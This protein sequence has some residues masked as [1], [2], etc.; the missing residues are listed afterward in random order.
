MSSLFPFDRPLSLPFASGFVR[1]PW[2]SVKS[3]S[4]RMPNY[5]IFF[6]LVFKFLC[7]RCQFYRK[8]VKL[9]LLLVR[10]IHFIILLIHQLIIL[11]Y[12]KATFVILIILILFV[13]M[14]LQYNLIILQLVK[15]IPAHILTLLYYKRFMCEWF[16]LMII[17]QFSKI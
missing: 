5:Y 9:R 16:F 7:S 15:I 14:L 1:F 6:V 11:I 10:I 17:I 4:E 12:K 8:L 2:M 13:L 3:M